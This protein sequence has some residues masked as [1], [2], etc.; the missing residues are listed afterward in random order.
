MVII[1]IYCL[2]SSARQKVN[3]ESL[4][5]I[6]YDLANDIIIDAKPAPIRENERALTLENLN[7]LMG[8]ESFNAKIFTR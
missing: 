2:Y 3:A 1:Q 7:V 5:S 8:L 4:G 6:R